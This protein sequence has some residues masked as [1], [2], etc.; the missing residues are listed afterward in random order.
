MYWVIQKD[1]NT[2]FCVEYIKPQRKKP[3]LCVVK[4]NCH[5]KVASFNDEKAVELFIEQMKEFIK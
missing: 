2:K 5:I 3:C 1:N 4:D